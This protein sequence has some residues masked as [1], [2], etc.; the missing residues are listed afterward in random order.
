MNCTYCGGETRIAPEQVGFDMAGTPVYHRFAYCDKCMQKWDLDYRP[1]NN[2]VR[3]GDSPLSI[4]ACVLSGVAFI[5]PL[6]VFVAIILMFLAFLFA[7][8]DLGINNKTQRHVGSGVALV[9]VAIAVV[10]VF[11]LR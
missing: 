10:V 2:P 4:T 6:P 7:L 11:F 1:I 5:I 9:F 8:I 3:K